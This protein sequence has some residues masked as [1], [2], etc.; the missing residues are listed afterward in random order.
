MVPLVSLETVSSITVSEEMSING[1]G[2]QRSLF[3]LTQSSTMP[4]QL[5]VV[6]QASL[7]PISVSNAPIRSAVVNGTS[8]VAMEDGD[9]DFGGSKGSATTNNDSNLKGVHLLGPT[10]REMVGDLDK[11]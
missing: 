2:G 6:A 7:K 5:V 10:I 4:I 11:S 9:D 3:K 8:Q 1:F